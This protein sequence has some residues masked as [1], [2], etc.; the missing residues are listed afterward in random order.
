MTAEALQ[1]EGGLCFGTAVGEA[2]PQFA[3]LRGRAFEHIGQEAVLAER[4]DERPIYPPVLAR[5]GDRREGLV[6]EAARR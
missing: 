5:F 6:P 3:Q 1:R 4:A 2:F